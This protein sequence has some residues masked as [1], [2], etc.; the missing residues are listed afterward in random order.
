[1]SNMVFSRGFE[2]I[3][4]IEVHTFWIM[5][6]ITNHVLLFTVLLITYVFFHIIHNHGVPNPLDLNDTTLLTES[7]EVFRTQ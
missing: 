6:A 4:L 7:W 3:R 2:Q 5:N 1:M